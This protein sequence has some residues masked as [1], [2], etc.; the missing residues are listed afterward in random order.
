MIYIDF[1][2]RS[3]VDIRKAG[4][5][6]YAEDASTSV[7]CL[8]FAVKDGPVQLWIPGEDIPGDLRYYIEYGFRVE[9][10]NA[11][12]ERAIWRNIMTKEPY[13]WLDIPDDQWA[14]SASLAASHALPRAL[15]DACVALNL[16]EKK[17][18]EGRRIMMKMARPRKPSKNDLSEWNTKPEDFR[19]LYNYCIQDVKAERGIGHA[20][21]PLNDIERQVWLLDQKINERGIRVDMEAVEAA[22][23]M[24]E[25]YK[26]KENAKV[27]LLTNGAVTKI[28][29]TSRLLKWLQDKGLEIPDLTKATVKE[30]LTSGVDNPMG[31][32]LKVRQELSMTSVAKYEA[33]KKAVCSDGRLRDLLMYH[34]ASTGRWTGKLVQP[35][36][37]PKNKFEGDLDE[38]FEH[39]KDHRFFPENS[40]NGLMK[41]LS[42]TIRGVFIPSEGKTF[43][44]GDFAG[45]E[46]RVL[47]WLA[48]DEHAL[49][50]FREGKDIYVELAKTIYGKKEI[51]ADERALGKVGI[52]GAGYGMGKDKFAV[53]CASWGLSVNRENSD[54]AIDAY[55]S[56]YSSV[57]QLWNA[58]DSA[59]K[60]A[61]ESGKTIK[62]GKVLWGMSRG[63]LFCRLPSGR[64]LAYYQ[65]VIMPLDT[66][67]GEKRPTLTYMSVNSV[68]R[69]W[70]RTKTYGGKIVENITQAI[71]RDLM[72]ESMLRLEEGGYDIVLTVHDEIIS[73]MDLKYEA[74]SRPFSVIM[75]E[76]PEWAKGLPV[77]VEGWSG[78]RYLK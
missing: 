13:R 14:C 2:T 30:F 36:N 60:Q 45:I 29:Q 23:E 46:A 53:T 38:Y 35:H 32:V 15:E 31:P 72:A 78:K 71:A 4:A 10:H 75:A 63:F 16:Q 65:P 41:T 44:G 43:Y 9:A 37:F 49:Q 47:L 7:L 19:K 64:C 3:K 39:L 51:N 8:A 18:P 62:C 22:I 27:S 59:A 67:W 11:F 20:L 17:D 74:I 12:F 5:W 55:R 77:E 76:T 33:I 24:A 28:S 52:L 48:G 40:S 73:E 61:V 69:K 70:E 58:M 26:E 34:G 6:R 56:K 54:K 1:E 57:V 68:T 50:G 66:P 25:N 42:Q 21:R